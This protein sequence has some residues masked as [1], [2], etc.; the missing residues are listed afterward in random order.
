M[1]EVPVSKKKVSFKFR[2][3]KSVNVNR[4]DFRTSNLL[5]KE[6]NNNQTIIE[7]L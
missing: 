5:K 4:K 1:S 3:W 6:V 2:E 7:K